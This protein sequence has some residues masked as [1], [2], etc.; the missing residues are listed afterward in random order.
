M[1]D[2]THTA[3][4]ARPTDPDDPLLDDQRENASGARGDEAAFGDLTTLEDIAHQ[5]VTWYV[6]RRAQAKNV[7]GETL[8]SYALKFSG[9]FDLEY[10]RTQLGGGMFRVI[11]KRRNRIVIRAMVPIEG[12]ARY[13]GSAAPS[14]AASAPAPLTADAI[15]EAVERALE[16]RA[17]QKADRDP[18]QDALAIIAGMKAMNPEPA[19]R[20]DS[21]QVLELL[22]EGME[23]QKQ[24][25]PRESGTTM[26]DA[27]LQLGPMLIGELRH[28]RPARPARTQPGASTAVVVPTPPSAPAPAPAAPEPSHEIDTRVVLAM[29]LGNAK[30]KGT[31][32][33]DI[34]DAAEATLP[35]DAIDRLRA[36]DGSM[37]HAYLAPV[38]DPEHAL[39]DAD[40]VQWLDAFL[41]SLRA[42]PDDAAAD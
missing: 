32:P 10:L 36:A 40:A 1:A 24:I 21:V 3:P 30:R 31:E 33:V 39:R 12:E 18:V 9:R 42:D 20:R 13:A 37:L 4:D 29:L 14:A 38:L 6:Y 16:R 26:A 2:L 8:D 7:P 19:E 35:D 11:G 41:D 34:A 28:A 22:R 27:L 25:T 15:A 17:P 5:D 23:I